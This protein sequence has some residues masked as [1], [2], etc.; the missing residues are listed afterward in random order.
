MTTKFKPLLVLFILLMVATP[1]HADNINV[2]VASNFSHTLQ[3][4]AGDF[5]A[6]T[7]HQLR[8]SSAST[9]KLYTQINHGAPFDIFMAADE[10]RPDRLIAEGKAS[11]ELSRVYAIGRLVLISNIKAKKTCQDVL[12]SPALKRLAIA[13]PK[14]APY[15]LAAQ[16]TLEKLQRW[17]TLKS[18][19]VMGENVAQPLQFVA[20]GNAGA[21]FV[22]QSMLRQGAQINLACEWAVPMDMHEPIKQK[23]LVLTKAS[24]KPAVIAFWHY[25]QTDT[26]KTII[27]NSG[28]DAP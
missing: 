23:M 14:T 20:T 13:N 16:Q 2:A 19:L 5:K 1:T 6:K 26:A 12:D 10:G 27:K 11:A 21:G 15:G 3:M 22:A 8:I 24:N 7:G 18:K 4:L 28:Y 17:Q 25:M 9:G